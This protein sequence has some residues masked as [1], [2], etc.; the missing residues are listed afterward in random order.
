MS[1]RILFLLFGLSHVGQAC[2]WIPG[3]RVTREG[4]SVWVRLG[5]E[6]G[7]VQGVADFV[8]VDEEATVAY[9]AIPSEAGQTGA[10]VMRAANPQVI[11]QRAEPMKLVPC[12]RP[13]EAA[14]IKLTR[15]LQ[16]FAID[17]KDWRIDRGRAGLT[18][19][20]SYRQKRIEGRFH[21]AVL[22]GAVEVADGRAWRHQ[23]V[24]SSRERIMRVSNEEVDA[25]SFGGTV[26]VYLQPG[27]DVEIQ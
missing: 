14:G 23:M 6:A 26:F 24:V 20:Y 8:G 12:E 4:E 5:A 27:K 15:P 1:K 2:L 17:L 16:W 3:E 10:A 25:Q 22:P 21:Y 13:K 18:L 11:G 19:H 7:E 9:L